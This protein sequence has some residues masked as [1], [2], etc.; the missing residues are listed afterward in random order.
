MGII[1]HLK[2]FQ[3]HI[4]LLFSYR[5]NVLTRPP[6]WQWTWEQR[7]SPMRGEHAHSHELTCMCSHPSHWRISD[8]NTRIS[9]KCW[10]RT[11][12]EPKSW[13]FPERHRVFLLCKAKSL[14]CLHLTTAEKLKQACHR[15]KISISWVKALHTTYTLPRSHAN[16]SGFVTL[17]N[18]CFLTGGPTPMCFSVQDTNALPY[19]YVVNSCLN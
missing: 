14:W 13:R 1:S 2:C 15:T 7:E 6:C 18:I 8:C 11:Y 10:E 12:F 4:W 5:R 17:Y 16:S 3:T 9:V 19:L